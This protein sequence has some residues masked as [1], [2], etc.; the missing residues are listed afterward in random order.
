LRRLLDAS[1]FEPG[2]FPQT[3]VIILAQD[4]DCSCS[5][6]LA[7]SAIYLAHTV[8]QVTADLAKVHGDK[9]R[10]VKL[11][12]TSPDDVRAR[13][14]EVFA[15]IDVVV[16]NAGYGFI[17]AFEEMTPDE[18][19]GQIDTNFLGRRACDAGGSSAPAQTGHQR[20]PGSIPS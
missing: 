20:C 15:R 4:H 3:S 17:G 6:V 5:A 10:T 9:I 8:T 1:V 7:H 12:V 11:D 19:K 2:L 16:N 18:F 13:A 14:V